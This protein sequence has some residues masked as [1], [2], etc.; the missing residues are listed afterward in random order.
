MSFEEGTRKRKVTEVKLVFLI[1][2]HNITAVSCLFV[3]GFAAPN[4][5]AIQEGEHTK[6]SVCPGDRRQQFERE[7][8]FAVTAGG[9]SVCITGAQGGSIVSA[10]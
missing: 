9:I 5:A 10:N 3:K 4:P 7:I 8:E 1:A 6:G 2:I